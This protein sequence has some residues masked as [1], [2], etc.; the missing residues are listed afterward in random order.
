[1]HFTVGLVSS[2][3]D[4][5]LLGPLFFSLLLTFIARLILFAT[6]IWLMACFR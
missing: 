3:R 6:P 2:V 5:L 1:M 4:F